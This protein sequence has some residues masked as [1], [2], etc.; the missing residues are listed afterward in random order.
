[1]TRVRLFHKGMMSGAFRSFF[2]LLPR[3]V[4]T[5]LISRKMFS[6]YSEI[7]FS[8][9]F[10]EMR[11]NGNLIK[12]NR[13]K[14]KINPPEIFNNDLQFLSLI[15]FNTCVIKRLTRRNILIH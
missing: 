13:N 15:L 10:V 3:G 11:A 8:L 7:S 2:S 1:M 4:D 5:I 14:N 12:F 9:N 6:R